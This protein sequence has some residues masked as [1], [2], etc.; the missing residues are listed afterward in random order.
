[1][2]SNFFDT[3]DPPSVV[4]LQITDH[5]ELDRQFVTAQLHTAMAVDNVLTSSPLTNKNVNSP[6]EI[7]EHFGTITYNKGGSILRMIEHFIGRKTLQKGL[8]YYLNLW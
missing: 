2:I 1:L 3:V 8:K 4:G 7:D 6:A 5:Y